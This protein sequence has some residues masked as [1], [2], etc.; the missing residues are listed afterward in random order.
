MAGLMAFLRR[1]RQRVANLRALRPV[2][3]HY[4]APPTLE[5]IASPPPRISVITPSYNQ[6]QFLDACIRSVLDQAYPN[7]EFVIF[8]G[9]STDGSVEIIKRYADHLTFWVSEPDEGQSSAIN[10]GVAKTT[11]PLLT[12]LNSDDFLLPGSLATMA[13]AY[14]ADPNASFFFGDGWRVNAAGDRTSDFFPHGRVSFSWESFAYGLNY[15]LQPSTFINRKYVVDEPLLDVALNW[16]MDTDLWLRLGTRAAPR[17]VRSFIAAS[18]EYGDTKTAS[19]SFQRVEELRQ[20]AFRH[21]HV[22]MTPGVV[23]YFLDTLRRFTDEQPAVFPESFTMDIDR[24]WT[25]TATSLAK[26]GCR[27]DGF[28][29]ESPEQP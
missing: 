17:A 5:D 3:K 10:K 13:H 16:G 26:Y 28:P 12:W 1:L 22:A 19:G 27:P 8:D 9:G 4:P 11:G 21:T 25:A 15:L 2:A 29:S 6:G 20:I 7:L 24:F 18:R 23:C 14:Q